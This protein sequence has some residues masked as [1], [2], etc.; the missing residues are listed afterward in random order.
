MSSNFTI[1]DRTRLINEIN[2]SVNI[3]VL[4]ASDRAVYGTAERW[5]LPKRIRDTL[6]DD[7][8]GYAFEKRDRLLKSGRFLPFDVRLFVVLTP[9]GAHAGKEYDHMICGVRPDPSKP[10]EWLCMDNRYKVVRNLRTIQ[11]DPD[12]LWVPEVID[13]VTGD[14]QWVIDGKWTRVRLR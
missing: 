10:N 8:D 4:Y 12:S 7:C 6:T 1:E 9:E 2:N 14:K 3:E 11:Y 5:G 13:T